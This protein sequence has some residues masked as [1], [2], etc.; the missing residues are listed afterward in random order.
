MLSDAELKRLKSMAARE[1]IPLGTLAYDLFS[2][3]F[4][5]AR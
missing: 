3:A 4:R 2:R 1:R 5:R